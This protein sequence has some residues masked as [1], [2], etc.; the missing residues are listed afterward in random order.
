I[1]LGE[2]MYEALK[3]GVF[4]ESMDEAVSKAFEL[5]ESGDVVLF[6]PAGASFDM[7]QDYEERGREFKRAV[8]RLVR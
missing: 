8:E 2:R 6:S 3:I 5:A 7:F 4:A 1:V